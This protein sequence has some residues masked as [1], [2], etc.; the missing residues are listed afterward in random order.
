MTSPPCKYLHV[1]MCTS[2]GMMR[3]MGAGMHASIKM[4]TNLCVIQCLYLDP[5]ICISNAHTPNQQY[6]TKTN[7]CPLPQ[8]PHTCTALKQGHFG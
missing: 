8:A 2:M 5:S 3:G 7:L 6:T 4:Q 1:C